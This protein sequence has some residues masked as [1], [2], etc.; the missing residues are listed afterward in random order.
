MVKFLVS[1]SLLCY[2]SGT[3]LPFHSIYVQVSYTEK[4]MVWSFVKYS[5]NY[6]LGIIFYSN[7]VFSLNLI[8]FQYSTF[9]KPPP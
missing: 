7:F 8:M 6:V 5:V 4:V 9:Y 2:L 1:Q 3:I